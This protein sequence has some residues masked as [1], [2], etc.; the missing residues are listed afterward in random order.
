[1][2]DVRVTEVL[3]DLRQG[4][5][6]SRE[7][8]FR[9][10][11]GEL[12]RLAGAQM[13][14][15][16]PGHTLTPTALVHEAYLR[17]LGTT[18]D[19][20]DRSHFLATAARAMRSILV[21]HARSRMALKR[22]GDRKRV[23]IEADAHAGGRPWEDVIAVHEALRRLEQ[24]DAESAAVVEL[25]FFGGLGFGDVARVRG[26]SERSVHRYWE[27]ARMWLYREIAS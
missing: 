6:G 23:T 11:Y 2:T 15:E 14:R 26:V 17:L 9:L 20:K 7:E 16:A 21:D 22:G 4:T 13:R 1:M 8:L 25:R 24:V 10:V 18:P 27:F 5:A 12:H 3:A 19:W